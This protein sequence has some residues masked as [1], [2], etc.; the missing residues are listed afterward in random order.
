MS[1]VVP[2][3][4]RL[5]NKNNCTF[6]IQSYIYEDWI[7]EIIFILYK[8]VYEEDRCIKIKEHT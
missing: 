2:N 5:R 8:L 4:H 6:R 7:I 3:V 1:V